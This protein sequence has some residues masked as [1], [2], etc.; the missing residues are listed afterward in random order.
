MCMLCYAAHAGGLH[1]IITCTVQHDP[2]QSCSHTQDLSSATST[3]RVS[4]LLLSFPFLCH[5]WPLS[6]VGIKFANKRPYQILKDVS[7]VLIP[8]SCQPCRLSAIQRTSI[9]S[10]ECCH[11][12]Q[13]K[14]RHLNAVTV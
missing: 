4:V 11:W 8:V 2:H 6:A 9:S 3:A 13:T 5:Q 10:P 12:H 7:G 1:H 14:F